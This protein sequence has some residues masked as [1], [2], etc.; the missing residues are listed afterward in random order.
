LYKLQISPFHLGR[1][2]LLSRIGPRILLNTFIEHYNKY[3][4]VVFEQISIQFL[5]LLNK[6]IHLKFLLHAD[7][8]VNEWKE[9]SCIES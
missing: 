1:Q 5:S 9:I 2:R 6:L 8:V 3:N 4:L 7:N